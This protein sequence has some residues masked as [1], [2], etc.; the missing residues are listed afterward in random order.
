MILWGDNYE[1]PLPMLVRQHLVSLEASAVGFALCALLFIA[2]LA[3]DLIAARIRRRGTALPNSSPY[4]AAGETPLL[5]LLRRSPGVIALLLVS[6]LLLDTRPASVGEASV[7]VAPG[8]PEFVF[9]TSEMLERFWLRLAA[10]LA[11]VG[12]LTWLITLLESA[13]LRRRLPR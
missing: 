6:Y 12:A 5:A 13:M 9:G 1:L 11:V 10:V 7:V 3:V 4:E 2:S 8:D